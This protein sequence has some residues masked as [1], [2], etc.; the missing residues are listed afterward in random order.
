[1]IAGYSGGYNPAA[2]ALAVGGADH[3][4][5]GVM[6]FDGLFAEI[7]KFVDW[8]AKH[9]PAFFLT[10]YGKAA[11]T[12]HAELQRMLTDRGV[13]FGTTLPARLTAGS[14]T[15]LAVGDDVRHNDF[16]TRAWVGDPLKAALARIPDF[17]RTRSTPGS[18]N[19]R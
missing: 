13:G 6:L 9:P 5:H 11:R 18:G 19:K 16:M 17:A 8:L 7:D 12:E 3:R 15:L 1:V 4:V 2:F 14:V 10:A